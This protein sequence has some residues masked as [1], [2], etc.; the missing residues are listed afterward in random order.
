MLVGPYLTRFGM[1]GH[2]LWITMAIIVNGCFGTRGF[3]KGIVCRDAAIAFYAVDLA[4]VVPFY[5]L[6]VYL[7]ITTL[8][9]REIKIAVF[10]KLHPAAIMVLCSGIRFSNKN[11][12]LFL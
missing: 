4:Q 2:T 7:F 5:L 6:G 12:L 3:D 10:T 11:I 9:Y 1:N 8:A